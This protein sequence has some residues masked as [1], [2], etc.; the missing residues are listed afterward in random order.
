MRRRSNGR[1]CN[2]DKEWD[3]ENKTY[4]VIE[5]KVMKEE[6]KEVTVNEYKEEQMKRNRWKG[7]KEKQ[8]KRR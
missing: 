6:T 8:R 4:L 2:E 7:G 3:K 1:K 5:D